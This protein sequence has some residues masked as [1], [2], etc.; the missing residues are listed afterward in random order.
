MEDALD[1][2]MRIMN[3][4]FDPAYGEAWTRK[5]VSDAMTLPNSFFDLADIGGNS[6]QTPDKAVGFT[7]SRS[8]L[9]EEELLLLAVMPEQRRNGIGKA[10]LRKLTKSAQGRGIKRV[11]LEMR[12]KNPAEQLYINEGFQQIGRRIDYYRSGIHGPLDAITY[13]KNIG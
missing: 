1:A 13:T 10:L 3:A 8:V 11:F 12:E 2:I 4:A 7:L 9:D 5:Q 6:P